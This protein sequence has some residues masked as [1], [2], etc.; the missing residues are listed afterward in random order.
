MRYL[1]REHDLLRQL[2]E[3]ILRTGDASLDRISLFRR[4]RRAWEAHTRAEEATLYAEL[5]NRRDGE[6]AA[7]KYSGDH[8]EAENLLSKLADMDI[9]SSTWLRE[10]EA[11]KNAVEH[12]LDKEED[13]LFPLAEKLFDTETER[14]LTERLAEARHAAIEE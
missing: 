7:F 8:K 6:L 9:A 14:A 5:M 3:Q 4:F 10:F 13:E 2:G 11:L 12:H 1:Q